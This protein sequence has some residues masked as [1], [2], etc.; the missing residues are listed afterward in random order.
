MHQNLAVILQQFCYVKFSV[1][2]FVPARLEP[3]DD[4]I[5]AGKSLP[6]DHLVHAVAV[7]LEN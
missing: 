2:V 6:H 5:V 4:A 7:F 3:L 1:I